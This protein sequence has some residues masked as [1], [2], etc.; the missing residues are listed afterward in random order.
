MTRVVTFG[1]VMMRLSPPS[2]QRFTQSSNFDITYGGG[3]ANVAIGLSQW[4]VETSHITAFP[5]DDLGK[6]AFAYLNKN[7]V[8]TQ[9]IRFLPGRLGLYFLE[10]GA[11]VRASKIVYDREF[12][13]FSK[14]QPADYDWKMILKDAAVFHWTG[15]TPALSESAASACFEAI[16]AA[17]ELGVKV[18]GDITFRKNLWKYGKTARE[19]LS[20]IIHYCNYINC[21]ES[22][23]YELFGISSGTGHEPYRSYSQQL[24]QKFDQLE[25]VI[26]TKRETINASHNSLSGFIHSTHGFF[27][28][29]Q[30]H[31]V[32]IVDRIGGGDALMAGFI[33]G[34]LQGWDEQKIISFATAASVL[35]HSVEGDSL[36]ASVE[37]VAQLVRGES[38]GRLV[39]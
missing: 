3:E 33:Y 4:G 38:V 17:R 22:E 25:L 35:K 37:E 16:R 34:L 7:N 12:S 11:S 21:G 8:G 24:L 27:E 23:A 10:K 29:Q 15:I 30:F 2:F 14:A 32:P 31:I 39:R 28:T 26:G 5:T 18:C 9:Y 36:I 13:S 1:E 19:V 20:E 6:A